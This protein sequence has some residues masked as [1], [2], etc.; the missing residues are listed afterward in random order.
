MRGLGVSTQMI[1]EH[2]ANAKCSRADTQDVCSYCP[3]CFWELYR[4]FGFPPV[5]TVVPWTSWSISRISLE[6][7]QSWQNVFS[8]FVLNFQEPVLFSIAVV[9]SLSHVWLFVTP[10]AAAHQTSLSFTISW[11]LLRLMSIE[12][13]MPSNCLILCHH[14]ILLPSISPSI[15]VFSMSWL[16]A[17]GNQSIGTSVQYHPFK[18]YSGWFHLL[19]GVICSQSKRL[20]RVFSSTTAQRNQFSELSLLY[21]PTP[22]C[23]STSTL[24]KTFP[25]YLEYLSKPYMFMGYPLLGQGKQKR[26]L[27]PR[28][29]TSLAYDHWLSEQ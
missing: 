5:C 18:G 17:S 19:T 15:R 1:W 4:S 28:R 26:P 23:P 11:I 29:E 6:K 7:V 22:R 21:G 27:S 2:R 20:S 10:W 14:L 16:F 12:L 24:E 25:K 9:H 13:M 3:M 8:S